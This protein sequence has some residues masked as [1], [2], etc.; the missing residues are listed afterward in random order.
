MRERAQRRTLVGIASV[1]GFRGLPGR[2]RVF[3]VEGG[4]DHLS[5]KPARRARRIRRRRR[6]DLPGLHRD[7]DD[8]ATIPYRMPFLTRAGRGRPAHGARHRAR[9]ALLRAAVADGDGSA[10]AALRAAADLR[11]RGR[12]PDAQARHSIERWAQRR[13][14]RR[15]ARARRRRSRIASLVPSLTELLFALGPRRPRRRAHRILRSSARSAAR[16][17]RSAAPRIRTSRCCARSRPTHLVVNVDENRREDVDAARAFVPHVIVTHPIA[18][19]DNAALFALFGESSDAHAKPLRWPMNSHAALAS[20]EDAMRGIAARAR[21]LSH[22]AQAVDDGVA[23]RR[24]SARRWR[25]SAGTRVPAHS[26]ARY[27]ERRRRRRR[28][29]R[30]RSASCCRRSRTRFARATYAT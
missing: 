27:P 19:I 1:A 9:A 11:S 3:G 5:R 2:G 4:R 23:R 13:L 6:D 25:G 24:T 17:R 20:V 22:L 28:V 29:A 10:R 18:P 14:G 30:R 26:D 12:R 16:C 21:A 15:R 8:R 7:A